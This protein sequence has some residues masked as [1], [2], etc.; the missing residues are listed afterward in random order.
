MAQSD[1]VRDAFTKCARILQPLPSD[2]ERGRVWRAFAVL[3]G[4][5]RFDSPKP[6]GS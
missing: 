1:P 5:V 6:E 3:L 2:E 4:M